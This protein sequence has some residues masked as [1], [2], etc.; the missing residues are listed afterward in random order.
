MRRFREEKGSALVMV[1]FMMLILTLLGVA[2]LSAAVGGARR[3]LTR[4]NDIQ[5]LQLTQKTLD[6]SVAY[7]AEKLDGEKLKANVLGSTLQN[8]L[9]GIPALQ[10]SNAATGEGVKTELA[11][12]STRLLSA[13]A[14]DDF[15]GNALKKESSYTVTLI[16]QSEINGVK[17]TLKQD[18]KVSLYPDFLNYAFGSEQDLILNGSPTIK[19]NIYAG[20]TLRVNNVANYAYRGQNLQ[21]TSLFPRMQ[22]R[23]D[24]SQP[25]AFIQSLEDFTLSE[26][27]YAPRAV[28]RG[29]DGA[30]L[31]GELTIANVRKALDIDLSQVRIRKN[32]QFVKVDVDQSFRDKFIQALGLSESVEIADYASYLNG[33]PNALKMPVKPVPPVRPVDPLSTDKTIQD[34]YKKELDAYEK[35][36]TDYIQVQLPKYQKEL[37]D[38]TTALTTMKSTVVFNGDLNVDGDWLKGLMQTAK[39]ASSWLIVNGNLT[40]NNTLDNTPLNIDSSILVTGAVNLGGKITVDSTLLTLGNTKIQDATITGVSKSGS[41]KEIVLISKGPILLNR[42]DAFSQANV[43]QTLRGFFYTDAA[44][45]LYGVGSNFDLQGGFF[46]KGNLTVNA[47]VGNSVEDASR[48]NIVFDDQTISKT[49]RFKVDYNDQVFNNQG[50]ALPRVDQISVKAEKIEL[51]QESQIPSK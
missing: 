32:E 28:N 41:V 12:A 1:M 4:E 9:T 26:N 29:A 38:L 34:Q 31:S 42:V 15:A 19:G 35:A 22:N 23:A 46:A 18:V 10:A 6:E 47:V 39:S 50:L 7:I 51:I 37:S 49:S 5:S 20:K 30:A 8:V 33:Y 2:V 25:L 27:G 13:K 45:E 14:S 17:R 3:T 43:A 24:G 16:A 21:K 36:Y 48:Q 40:V 44:A 11:L